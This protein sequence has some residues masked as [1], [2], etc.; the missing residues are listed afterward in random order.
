M[1][2]ICLIYQVYK[3]FCHILTYFAILH[4]VGFNR[5]FGQKSNLL[6]ASLPYINMFLNK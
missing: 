2:I 4:I 3:Y 1:T 6:P 5:A